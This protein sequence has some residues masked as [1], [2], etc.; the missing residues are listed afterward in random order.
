MK[1]KKQFFLIC[2]LHCIWSLYSVQVYAEIDHK[3]EG[4]VRWY[5]NYGNYLVEVGKYPDALEYFETAYDLSTYSKNIIDAL[6]AKAN[7]LAAYL[8]NPEQASKVYQYLHTKYPKIADVALYRQGFVLYNIGSLSDA[9][10][11][12]NKYLSNYPDGRYRYQ[13]EAILSKI[14]NQ[15]IPKPYIITQRPKV[16]IRLC[17]NSANVY[18]II[19]AACVSKR[20]AGIFINRISSCR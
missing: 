6:M 2:F 18:L 10:E 8:E 20:S 1:M 17:R 7:L 19:R 15:I 12:L 5:I 9:G 11:I 16:R 3:T 4:H 13:S 14:K